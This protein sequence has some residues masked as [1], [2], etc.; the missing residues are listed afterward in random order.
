[1]K[2]YGKIR[3]FCGFTIHSEDTKILELDQCQKSYKAQSIIY[4]I[5]ESLIKNGWM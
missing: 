2:K 3:N 1:M 5:F 4:G